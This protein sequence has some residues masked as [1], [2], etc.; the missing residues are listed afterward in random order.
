MHIT[1]ALSYGDAWSRLSNEYA[2]C[3]EEIQHAASTL[4]LENVAKAK[5]IRPLSGQ[6]S[7]LNQAYRLEGCWSSLM[8]LS[9]WGPP[10]RNAVPTTSGRHLTLRQLGHVKGNVSVALIRHRDLLSRWLYSVAPMAS[11][12]GAVDIPV[13]LVLTE[14]AQTALLGRPSPLHLNMFEVMRDELIA[15]SPLSHASPFL[16]L[17]ASA[18]PSL[19]NVTDLSKE[20]G[21]AFRQIVVNRSIEFPP[22]Y[23]QAGLGVLTYFGT[24]LREKYPNHD[25]KVRIE[26][27]GLM[28]RLIIESENGDREII[29]KALQEYEMVV[30]GERPPESLLQN[31]AR[32]IELKNELRI[33]QVRIE[34]QRDIISL[35]GEQIVSL[36]QLIGHSMSRPAQP[37]LVN[38]QP[39]VTV[40]NQNT[41]CLE[42]TTSIPDISDELRELLGV[43]SDAGM[44]TRILDLTEAL[45]SASTKSTP[46]A[47]KNSSGVTKLRTFIEDAAKAG[48]KANELLKSIEGGIGVVQ[49]IGRKYNAIA[50]WCGAPQVPR[51]LLGGDA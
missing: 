30:L 7:P 17:A 44:R 18:Q 34:S 14:D 32:V 46:E 31:P 13:A 42:I 23:H 4:T 11:R 33:A 48:T 26:Q 21:V 8:Q 50:E 15:L 37:L 5:P 12:V 40:T 27:D 1:S 20:D 36:R 9:G 43:V 38:V 24:I 35:Q 16:I 2:S 29:E 45:D 41:Q 10:P 49:G 6:D 47:V 22:Q 19:M 28:V 51:V 39:V 25:A 3:L